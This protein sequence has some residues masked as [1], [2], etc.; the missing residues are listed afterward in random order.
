MSSGLLV[1]SLN[2][3]VKIIKNPLEVDFN[4]CLKYIAESHVF[5]KETIERS[6][7]IVHIGTSLDVLKQ[8]P[9]LRRSTCSCKTTHSNIFI[10]N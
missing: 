9:S 3:V 2:T 8:D 7:T 1:E 6:E 5:G 10:S 4:S